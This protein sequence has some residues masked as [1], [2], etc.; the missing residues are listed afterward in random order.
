MIKQCSA[1]ERGKCDDGNNYKR[2]IAFH[3]VARERKVSAQLMNR[4]VEDHGKNGK[5][6]NYARK[7]RLR[8]AASLIENP[9]VEA[10]SNTERQNK[11]TMRF[12][13]SFEFRHC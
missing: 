10:Q 3:K 2:Q 1:S 7:R 4:Q 12:G 6:R 13:L 5:E 8:I 9:N 11:L